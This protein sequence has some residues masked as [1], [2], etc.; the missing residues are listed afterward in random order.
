M[1]S[2]RCSLIASRLL[3][4]TRWSLLAAVTACTASENSPGG[5]AGL[6]TVF[7]STADTI[8]AR[9]DGQ[10]PVSALRTMTVDMRIT[11]AADDTSL[12]S[13]VGEIDVDAANRVWLFDYQSNRLFIFD[14]TGKLVRR[15]GR[16]GQGPGEFASGSG[17]VTLPDTGAAIW[18]ARNARISFFTSTGDFRTSWPVPSGFFTSNGLYIDSS[19]SLY[20]R[21][22]VS[23]PREGE[24]L[25]RMGLVRLKDGGAFG[26]SLVP[27]DL[28]VERDTYIAVSADGNSRSST[29]FRHA[30]NYYWDWHPAGYFVA[31]HGGRYELVLERRDARPIVIRRTPAPVPLLPDEKAEEKEFIIWNMR[32]TQPA[33]SWTGGDLPDTKAPLTGITIARDGNIWARVATASE[34]IPADELPPQREKGPPPRHYRTPTVYE[35]FSATGRFLGRVPLPPRTTL[36]QADGDY[37]WGIMRD[38]DDL[39]S[40]VRLTLNRSFREP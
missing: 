37:I 27:V 9:V 6:V 31:G 33:W 18:D 32:Q 16:Q 17:L 35:V 24:I 5:T 4:A 3:I 19:G 10:V 12:F 26:D 23:A 22:P 8:T 14:S 20:L 15:I 38:E 1:Q 21:R 28:P 39:P 40:V 29:S 30:P 25:G 7:D 34:R 2:K 36:F 11:P 13:E